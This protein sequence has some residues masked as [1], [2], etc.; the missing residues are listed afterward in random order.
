ML[1]TTSAPIIIDFEASGF[2]KDSYPIEVGFVGEDGEGWCSLIRPEAD[3]QHW[4]KDAAEVHHITRELLAERG[5]SASYVAEQLNHYLRGSVVYT[6]GWAHDYVWL[7]RLFESAD[8]TP[9]FKLQ[10][11]R[12]V[13]T[14]D[15]LTHWHA[16]KEKVLGELHLSRHRASMDA[17]VLQVT[18]Q[19]TRE[20]A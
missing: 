17:K 14:T 19:R 3:W 16:T 12:Y 9:F 4:D 8:R 2:G 20:M 11:L 18:W 7:S 6:D 5:H 1:T 13:L 10:D 15:Q